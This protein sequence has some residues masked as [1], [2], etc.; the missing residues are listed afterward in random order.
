MSVTACAHATVAFDQ[1]GV[2]ICCKHC[3]QVWAALPLEDGVE[4]QPPLGLG[5]NDIRVAPRLLAAYG[6]AA[7]Q[8]TAPPLLPV[9]VPR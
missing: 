4:R 1:G 3:P 7:D 8:Q 6:G 5:P 9:K 2:L